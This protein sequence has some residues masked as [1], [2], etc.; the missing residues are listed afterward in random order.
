MV[1][2]MVR[3]DYGP[4]GKPPLEKEIQIRER[5]TPK[6]VLKQIVP[7]VEGSACCDPAEVKGIDGVTIDPLANRWWT[8]KINGTKK[9]ASPH[10]SH[11]KAGD[12]MEWEYIE[13]R[14]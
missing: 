11:L 10:K 7:V 13:D 9:N 14:Q 4:A 6:E 8:L 1:P 5:A 2:I 12:R 3:I